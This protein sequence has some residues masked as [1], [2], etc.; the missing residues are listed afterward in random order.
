[1]L[2]L[3]TRVSSIR[4]LPYY[5]LFFSV[6][7]VCTKLW[8]CIDSQWLDIELFSMHSSEDIKIRVVLTGHTI[9]QKL[10]FEYVSSIL[11]EVIGKIILIVDK[12]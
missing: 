7:C 8:L 9:R 11:K 10:F 12:L 4:M 2:T 1:M 6:Y 5:L 3:P